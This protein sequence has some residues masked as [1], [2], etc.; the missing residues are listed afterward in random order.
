MVCLY[1]RMCDEDIPIELSLTH[2]IYLIDFFLSVNIL[3]QIF[4]YYSFCTCLFLFK[5]Q[6][7]NK[8]TSSKTQAFCVLFFDLLVDL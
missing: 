3:L 2:V 7:V 1:V 8:F 4:L 5:T 6:Q